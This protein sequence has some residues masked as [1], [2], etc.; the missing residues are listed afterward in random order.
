LTE[1]VITRT[2]EGRKIVTSGSLVC[3][4]PDRCDK[5]H[6][7]THEEYVR[8]HAL[9]HKLTDD[10][11]GEF[12]NLEDVER[13]LGL[14][15]FYFFHK[16]V[17]GNDELTPIPFWEL[18]AFIAEPEWNVDDLSEYKFLPDA[19]HR[20]PGERRRMKQVEVPRQCQ[21][22]SIG[23]RAH[24]VFEHLHEYFVNDRANFRTI[25]RSATGKNTRDTLA[26]IRR[27]STKSQ[28][29]MRLYGIYVIRCGECMKTSQHHLKATKCPKCGGKKRLAVKRISLIN[30]ARGAGGLGQDMVSFRFLTDIEDADAIAAYSVWVAGLETETTGQRPDRYKW[31]DPQTDKNARTPE[32]RAKIIERFDDS[33]RQLQF[34]GEMLV[35]DTRKFV[36]DFAGKIRQE[37]LRSLFFSLHRK[38]RWPTSEPDSAPYV[39]DGLRYYFPI[40]GNGKPALDA[41]QV[42]DLERQ[43]TERNFSAEYMNEPLDPS[44]ALFKREHFKVISPDAAPPEVRYGLG[45]HLAPDQARELERLNVR[46]FALNSIDPAGKE[47]QSVKGDDTFIVGLR[48]DRYGAVYI[49]YLAAGKWTSSQVW[50]QI[51]TANAYN[52]PEVNDYEMPASEHHVK[53]SFEKWTREKSEA[54]GAPVLIPM[55]FSSQ[56]KSGKQSRIEQMEQWTR[57][58]RFF[59]LSTAA[60]P[61]LIEKY[62]AQWIGYLVMD[63]DDGPDATSRLIRY[64]IVNT[65]EQ[66][67]T[68]VAGPQVTNNE[69]GTATVPVAL[70]NELALAGDTTPRHWGETGW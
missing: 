26:I 44:K 22:T 5:R 9:D 68:E 7:E 64:L 21:K 39:L 12:K 20:R 34:G 52:R 2:V 17:W 23:A 6:N 1:F 61:E 36:D 14:W 16:Y 47:E 8:R 37:P 43:M 38:V 58:G 35:L 65:Y 15:C 10:R 33:V 57:N 59:I 54:L 62:I 63:H 48:V 4:S 31:D 50:D 24:T 69:N 30:E 18:H 51:A 3:P 70:I 28:A 67:V 46:I 49:T 42:N 66:P 53:S 40:K 32:L 27:M 25:V 45:T 13:N 29:I 56:P 41:E 60:T 11:M 55:R 19:A